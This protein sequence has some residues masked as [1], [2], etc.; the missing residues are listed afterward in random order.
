[1]SH[2][3]GD[4]LGFAPRGVVKGSQGGT[5]TEI[6][7]VDNGVRKEKV[8]WYLLDGASHGRFQ[9]VER[10]KPGGPLEG[11]L[12]MSGIPHKLTDRGQHR[13]FCQH[14]VVEPFRSVVRGGKSFKG[15]WELLHPEI[16]LAQ[17][18]NLFVHQ[19]NSISLSRTQMRRCEQ[20]DI[21]R[22]WRS[23]R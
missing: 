16:R 12:T 17:S 13:M 14:P 7:S 22:I 20:G 2:G 10:V 19:K 6:R 11:R 23:G 9:E 15:S 21:F 4:V 8:S 1:M 5:L 3:H 18:G